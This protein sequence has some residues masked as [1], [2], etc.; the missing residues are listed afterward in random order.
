MML[1]Y[2]YNEPDVDAN[3]NM[4]H[5]IITKSEQ[6]IINEYYNYWYERMCDK[7][8]KEHV[9]ANYTKYD[10]IDDWII[11]NWAWRVSDE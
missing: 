2:S 4:I 6:E 9:D 5:N 7:F 8:G 3:G 1:Y 10:C 11:I